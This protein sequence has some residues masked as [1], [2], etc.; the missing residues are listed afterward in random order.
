MCACFLLY[1][2]QLEL[3]LL[4]NVFLELADG[5]TY[6]LHCVAMTDGYA[7]VVE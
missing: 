2:C 1:V 5:Q 3:N 6:L 7:A 4:L